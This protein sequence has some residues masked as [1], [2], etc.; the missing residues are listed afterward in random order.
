M[1]DAISMRRMNQQPEQPQQPVYVAAVPVSPG[2]Q[3]NGL[4]L[5]GFIT[6]LVGLVLTGGVLCPIGLILSLIALARRPRGFA[7]AGTVIGFVGSCGSCLVVALVVPLMAGGA[8]ALALVAAGGVPAIETVD[9]MLQV[10]TAIEKFERANHAAPQTLADLN[11]PKDMLEDG[12]GTPLEFT[13]SEQ[14]GRACWTLRSAGPDRQ[15]D[16]SDLTFRDCVET[17]KP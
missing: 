8:A 16:G 10:R 5:A 7:I 2:A 13:V 14:G 9:H 1:P 15:F 12:W 11:L 3:S 4:G 6:S 17:S